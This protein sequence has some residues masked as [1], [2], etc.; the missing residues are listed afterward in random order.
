MVLDKPSGRSSAWATG[1][2]RRILGAAK[3]GHAGTL[4]PLA[5]G[6]LPVAVGEATKTVPFIQDADKVYT[7][8]VRWG[9]ARATDDTEGVV[10]AASP[11]RP[12]AQ[13][14]AAACPRFVGVFAQVPPAYSSCKIGG[15]RAYALARQRGDV[16]ALASRMVRV[17]LFDCTAVP[18][19]DH[20]AFRLRLWQ[21]DL[22]ARARARLGVDARYG[23]SR[24][25]PAKGGGGRNDRPAGDF[26]GKSGRGCA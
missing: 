19:A 14:I 21:G 23:R 15:H 8:T 13:H 9:E 25:C 18:D 6:V 3:A 10:T 5:S 16:P 26:P 22:C 4:D 17:E 7:F 24:G 20:A 11:I 1:Q 12:S 2:V